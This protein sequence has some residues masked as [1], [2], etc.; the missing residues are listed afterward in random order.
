[1]QNIT[2][3]KALRAAILR[4]EKRQ[5]EQGLL[6]K[7]QFA[8]TYESL[9]PFNVLRKAVTDIFTPFELKQGLLETSAGI[10]SGYLSRILVVRDSKNPFL[11]LA[12]VFVQYGVTNVITKN[13][14][15]IMKVASAFVEKIMRHSPK[16]NS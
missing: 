3:V 7:E 13:S 12:G 1:M 11:R 15:S 10:L 9:K 16:E 2:S 8:V 4:L 6:V 14:E 5:T